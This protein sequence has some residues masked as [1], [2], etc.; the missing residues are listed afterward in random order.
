MKRTIITIM[1]TLALWP[2]R[3]AAQEEIEFVRGGC[4]P[5]LT[6]R[7]SESRN[8]ASASRR[9]LSA[10]ITTWD[11]SK[12]YKQ[13][14]ILLSFSDLDFQ[15]EHTKEFYDQ[16]LNQPGFESGIAG[17]GCVAD[18]F[19]EQS[20]GQLNLQFDVFGPYKTSRNAQSSN[21]NA[22][23]KNYHNAAKEEAVRK[24]MEENPEWDFAQYD[25]DGDNYVDQVV[26][27]AAGYAGNQGSKSYGYL[28]PST[29]GLSAA[30]NTPD[31]KK[32]QRQTSS[33]ELW[34]NNTSC[35]IG[36]ICHEFSHCLGL[37]DI[38]P[39]STSVYALSVCDEWDLMDGGNFTG[40]GWCPPNYTAQEKMY[41]GWLE[42]TELTEPTSITGMKPISEGGETYI[43]RHTD[44]EYYLLENHQ[45]TGWDVGLP[46][47]GLLITHVDFKASIWED[48]AVN[49]VEGHFRYDLVHADNL[50]YE[51]WNEFQPRTT[52]QWTDYEKRLH[53]RHLSTSPY[54][55]T[56]TE[57]LVVNR[58]LTDTSTPAAVMYNKN[59]AGVKLLGKSIDNIQMAED[60]TISFDFMME[61]VDVKDILTAE[62]SIVGWYDLNGQQL[63]A[64]PIQSGVYIAVHSD[65][66]KK[67]YL[68]R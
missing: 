44:N 53:N 18:Y 26:F 20:N 8:L 32:I 2:L 55:W 28:W 64:A 11:A 46:G 59:T 42:P 65:G 58:A 52:R 12:T 22:D 6:E 1:L 66:T 7:G 40:F 56:N 16:I 27:I 23:T 34:T 15:E 37:P 3:L 5:D 41:L 19:K 48:N 61:S 51:Q 14:V 17:K 25:W 67:K 29:G 38:Y 13:L 9:K 45:W 30:I 33:A 68:L 4:T 21:A 43:I 54:P 50:D 10:P 47:Q 24:M 31:S 36:T 57:T 60:G 63:T 39:T 35:G 49:N 62:Q